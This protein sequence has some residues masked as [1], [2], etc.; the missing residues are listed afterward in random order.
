[1][2]AIDGELLAQIPVTTTGGWQ[3]WETETDN[4]SGVKGV[5]DVYLVFTRDAININ[6]INFSEE[7]LLITGIENNSILSQ[8]NLYPN[9]TEGHLNI[10]GANGATYELFD[11]SGIVLQNGNINTQNEVITVEGL[12]KGI[13]FIKLIKGEAAIVEKIIVR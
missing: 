2:D 10:E 13:Y 6:W 4:F 3:T 5:H 1:L 9:P 12:S 8:I 7:E 11:N